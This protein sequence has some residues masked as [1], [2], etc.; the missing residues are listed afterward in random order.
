VFTLGVAIPRTAVCGSSDTTT[1]I[2][3]STFNTEVWK[4]AQAVTTVRPRKLFLP[5]I[6]KK[7]G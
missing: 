4:S 2:A 7:R 3:R 5:L 1:I 6:L